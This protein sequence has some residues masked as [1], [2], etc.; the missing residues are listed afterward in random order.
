MNRLLGYAEADPGCD[1]AFDVLDRYCEALVAGA[2]AAR[3]FPLFQRH[4]DNCDACREDTEGLVNLLM[5]GI[6]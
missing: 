3:L 5:P 1:A 6:L 2:D 4:I